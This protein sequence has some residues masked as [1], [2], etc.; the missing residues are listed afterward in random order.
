MFPF[1][2]ALGDHAFFIDRLHRQRNGL[3]TLFVAWLGDRPAGDVYVWLERA[4]EEPIRGH[5]PGVP[6]LTHLEVHRELRNRG[7]GSALVATVERYLMEE[8]YGRVALAVR[9]D[10][11]RAARLYHRL[12]YVDWG[13]GEVVCY[14][15]TTTPDGRIHEEA[16]LCHVLVKDL[17]PV[18]PVPRAEIRSIGASRRF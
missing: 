5:L 1:A 15:L 18:M 6:L 10:N 4:E 16:E 7:I 2:R 8:G 17:L 14:A 13:H 3:G 11:T 9:T 12:G